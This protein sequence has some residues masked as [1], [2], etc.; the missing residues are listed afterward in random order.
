MDVQQFCFDIFHDKKGFA[1]NLA[2]LKS[3]F[4]Y[5]ETVKIKQLELPTETIEIPEEIECNSDNYKTFGYFYFA[6]EKKDVEINLH[7]FIVHYLR[8]DGKPEKSSIIDLNQVILHSHI[9]IDAWAHCKTIS[10]LVSHLQSV[11]QLEIS[12]LKSMKIDE[13]QLYHVTQL[14]NWPIWPCF[15][16]VNYLHFA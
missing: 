7:S 8:N 9:S 1:L 16:V 4:K 10:P 11:C 12:L 3:H 13:K 2:T 14:L 15:L 5:A 6:S